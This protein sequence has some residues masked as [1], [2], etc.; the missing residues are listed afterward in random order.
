MVEDNN[1]RREYLTL[2][3]VDPSTGK[4][5]EVLISFDRMQVIGRRSMG[6]AKD[7]AFIYSADDIAETIGHL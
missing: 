4:T 7:C 5:C 2:D 3:A 1:S 6:H